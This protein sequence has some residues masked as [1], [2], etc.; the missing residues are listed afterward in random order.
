MRTRS[1]ILAVLVCS[2]CSGETVAPPPAPPVNWNS[3]APRPAIDAGADIVSAMERTL[4]ETY[5]RALASEGFAPLSP[6]LNDDAH[7]AS[8]GFQDANGRMA[9]V[10]AHEVLFGA[11]DQRKVV[12]DRVWRTPSEQTIEWTMSGVQARDWQGVPAKHRPVSFNGLAL[13]WTRDDGTIVDVH[14]YTDVAVI[15]GQLGVGPKELV[16]LPPAVPA[17]TPQVIEQTGSPDES[18]PVTI[19]R[20]ALDGLE[21]NNEGAYVAAMAD[22]VEIH[23]QGRAQPARGKDE[24][25]AYFKAMRKAIGQLDTTVDN[26]WGVAQY[27]VVEYSIAGEQLGP[28]GWIPAQ[29]D[30]VVRMELVDIA[31]VREGKIIRIWRYDNP[32]QIVGNPN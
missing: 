5:S 16:G 31:E 22:D 23:T 32:S 11:F 28:I 29:R 18:A 8:P 13:L 21:G 12:V 26:A 14:L 25:K 15:K 9:V 19:V 24:A 20:S 4:P 27:A 17:A 6:L 7:F 1:W 3:L 30:K 10:R 2:S